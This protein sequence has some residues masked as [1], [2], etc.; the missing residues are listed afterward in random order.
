[1]NLNAPG[2]DDYLQTI[3]PPRDAVLNEMEAYAAQHDFPIVGP[4]VGRMRYLL[5]GATQA[6]RGVRMCSGYVY[7]A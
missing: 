5:S 4:L 3:T 2:I 1:M 7:L 6:R